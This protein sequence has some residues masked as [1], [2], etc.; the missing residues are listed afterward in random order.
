MCAYA[1]NLLAHFF[2]LWRIMQELHQS[3]RMLCLILEEIRGLVE[4][5]GEQG[6][7]PSTQLSGGVAVESTIE[8]RQTP[9]R[10]RLSLILQRSISKPRNVPGPDIGSCHCTAYRFIS[11]IGGFTARVERLPTKLEALL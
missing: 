9:R 5:L 1:H 6:K 7:E 11:E 8:R 4:C 3:G 2:R 10:A